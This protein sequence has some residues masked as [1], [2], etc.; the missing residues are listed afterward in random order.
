MYNT[1]IFFELYNDVYVFVYIVY[2]YTKELTLRKYR[3]DRY[4]DR[5]LCVSV[6]KCI[7]LCIYGRSTVFLVMKERLVYK[8]VQHKHI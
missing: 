5:L 2:K 6:Y 8:S 4:T 7:R 3:R 1:F